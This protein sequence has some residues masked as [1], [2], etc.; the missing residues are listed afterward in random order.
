MQ[1]FYSADR[2]LFIIIHDQISECFNITHKLS[3][4]C[5]LHRVGETGRQII[6]CVCI[7]LRRKISVCFSITC[8]IL[9]Q[10]TLTLTSIFTP[11]SFCQYEVIYSHVVI[12][13]YYEVIWNATLCVAV[14]LLVCFVWASN[15][16][17]QEVN[18]GR[19]IACGICNS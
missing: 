14:C 7:I 5:F 16:K 10:L 19:N 6:Y 18:T 4:V 15:S 17:S 12:N 1:R 3:D 13:S 2:F 11:G 9:H 8:K